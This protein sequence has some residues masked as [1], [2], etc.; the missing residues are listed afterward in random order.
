[1][2]ITAII[3]VYNHR[4]K[5]KSVCLSILRSRAVGHIYLVNDG[6]DALCTD[7]LRQLALGYPQITLIEHS[8]N[9]G[10][11]A[12]L[13]SGLNEAK[14]AGY[15]HAFQIDADG[16]HVADIDQFATYALRYPS[17]IVLGYPTYDHSVP[18][19][20]LIARYA[21]HIWVWINTLSFAIKDSMCGYRIYPIAA[22]LESATEVRG[23]QMDFDT[24]ILIR[25]SWCGHLFI[26]LPVKVTYPEDGI[27]H[28]RMGKDNLLI[29]WMHTRLFF[30]MLCNLPRLLR[31]K[32]KGV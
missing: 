9:Q 18:R 17:A 21:T 20:R 19:H 15:S 28:F 3:P 27:S 4:Y 25:L 1:M 14:T 32:L 22:A 8:I 24:E 26:N 29:T 23:K 30:G 5:I 10:K 31:K 16:Q 11:G 6:S 2:R 12:A 7:V 13:I